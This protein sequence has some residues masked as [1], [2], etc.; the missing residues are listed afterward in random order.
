LHRFTEFFEIEN[1]HR[2]RFIYLLNKIILI[3]IHIASLMKMSLNR[4]NL[5]KI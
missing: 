5:I 3:I 1:K 4:Q 2:S